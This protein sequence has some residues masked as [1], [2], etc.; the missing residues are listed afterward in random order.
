MALD[1]LRGSLSGSAAGAGDALRRLG[2][3]PGHPPLGVARSAWEA[4]YAR[5]VVAADVLAV[6]A[7]STAAVLLEAHRTDPVLAAVSGLLV[8]VATLVA[9]YLAGA[10]SPTALGD[11][12]M[13]YRR[14]VRGFATA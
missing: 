3:R 4:A 9:T 8:A 6:V 13:E 1:P 5:W 7:V 10:W 2:L 11:D 14:L 12:G